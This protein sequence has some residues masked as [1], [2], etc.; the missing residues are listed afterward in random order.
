MEIITNHHWRQFK[1]RN[2]V[3]PEVL[4]DE[5]GWIDEEDD[6][7]DGYFQYRGSWYHIAD[8]MLATDG[9]F[10]DWHGYSC[11]TFFSAVLIRVSDDGEEYQVGLVLA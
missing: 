10:S 4:A 8:F 2:E 11:D 7:L 1:Y 3:P 5:F 6:Y 9:P